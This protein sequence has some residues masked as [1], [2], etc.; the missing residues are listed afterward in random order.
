MLFLLSQLTL[1]SISIPIYTYPSSLPTMDP[2][3]PHVIPQQEDDST[4]CHGQNVQLIR[5]SYEENATTIHIRFVVTM[6]H[7]TSME[8]LVS[9]SH[10]RFCMQAVQRAPVLVAHWQYFNN[11]PTHMIWAFPAPIGSDPTVSRHFFRYYSYLHESS[12]I[13]NSLTQ[14][15]LEAQ[16]GRSE[17]RVPPNRRRYL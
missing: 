17:S 11:G 8:V 16:F 5:M 14:D 15:I 7:R 1:N 6:G 3:A 4:P 12:E 10:W 2:A 9:R 13:A